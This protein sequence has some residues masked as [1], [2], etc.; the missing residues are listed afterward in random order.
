MTTA[1]E[2]PGRLSSDA[3]TPRLENLSI[4]DLNLM[5]LKLEEEVNEL[6]SLVNAL[7]IATER[8]QESKKALTELE[9]K[10]KEVQVPLTSL[11]YVPGKF[12][13]WSK[14]MKLIGEL[15]NP[16]KVLVSVG[17]GYYIE[18]DLKKADDYYDRRIRTV[19]EQMC[20]LQVILSG[21]AKQI[22]QTYSYLDQK[23]SMLRSAQLASQSAT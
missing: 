12:L 18:M 3:N 6:Q 2:D 17:T 23:L 5:I 20:K 1:E 8:F 7:T 9:K 14:N 21:K 22:N 10:N 16:D 19:E 4:Q 15:S 11:V 13:N